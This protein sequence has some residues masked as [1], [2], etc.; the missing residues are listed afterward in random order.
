LRRLAL[1]LILAACGDDDAPCG[2]LLDAGT[3]GVV[4]SV[5]STT[6]TYGDFDSARANDCGVPD[7]VTITGHQLDPAPTMTYRIAFCLRDRNDVG[8]AP[9][10]LTD[11]A[12]FFIAAEASDGCVYNNDSDQTPTGSVTFSGFCAAG[13]T[14]YAM[15][16]EASIPGTVTCPV[17]GGTPTASPATLELSGSASVTAF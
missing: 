12:D 15:S 17:D 7:S 2:N 3:S 10:P 6:T 5:A 16:F 11:V 8:A 4:L 1:A 13:G 9:I 14:P